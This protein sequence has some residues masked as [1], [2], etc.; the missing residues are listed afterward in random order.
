MYLKPEGSEVNSES[1]KL[2]TIAFNH[3][4]CQFNKK[5]TNSVKKLN[6]T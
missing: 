5:T 2:R 4:L 3:N 1:Y 6:F